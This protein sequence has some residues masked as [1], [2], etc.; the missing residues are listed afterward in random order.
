MQGEV[1]AALIVGGATVLAALVAGVLGIFE[2][3]KTRRTV[4]KANGQGTLV[5][6]V[7][8]VLVNQGRHDERLGS[9]E[10]RLSDHLKAHNQPHKRRLFS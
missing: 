5:Q 3:R 7:E 2:S 6:M 8:K 9:L 4:G 10:D 1:L